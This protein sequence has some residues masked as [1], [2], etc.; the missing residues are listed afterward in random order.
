MAA[1]HDITRDNTP[2]PPAHMDVLCLG[3]L[4]ALIEALLNLVGRTTPVLVS[5]MDVICMKLP[6]IYLTFT[7][8]SLGVRNQWNV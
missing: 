5:V 1:L 2:L 6:A 7:F 3:T 8:I 4:D